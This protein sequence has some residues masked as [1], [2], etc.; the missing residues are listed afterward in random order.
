M[1]SETVVDSMST[2]LLFC[3][4]WVW[5]VLVCDCV[6]CIVNHA[7]FMVSLDNKD[8]GTSG[9]EFCLC[10]RETW[11]LNWHLSGGK[12]MPPMVPLMW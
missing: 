11:Q 5:I 1:M 2:L 10:S 3:T 8:T 4:M 12:T 9:M 7:S 6:L